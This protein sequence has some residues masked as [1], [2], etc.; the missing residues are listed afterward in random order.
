MKPSIVA[1]KLVGC[2]ITVNHLPTTFSIF[3]NKLNLALLRHEEFDYGYRYSKSYFGCPKLL[4]FIIEVCNSHG[5]IDYIPKDPWACQMSIDHSFGFFLPGI[6]KSISSKELKMKEGHTFQ[7]LNSSEVKPTFDDFDPNVDSLVKY[8][9]IF[10]NNLEIS[11]QFY[12]NEL[13]LSLLDET[14]SMVTLI[15]PLSVEIPTSPLRQAL[16]SNAHDNTNNKIIN[17]LL[18]GEKFDCILRLRRKNNKG[19]TSITE[20]QE[21]L[22]LCADNVL[23][24]NESTEFSNPQSWRISIINQFRILLSKWT[25]KIYKSAVSAQNEPPKDSP[26]LSLYFQFAFIIRNG[27]KGIIEYPHEK[28][29]LDRYT[30]NDDINIINKTMKDPDGNIISSMPTSMKELYQTKER[31]ISQK[32]TEIQQQKHDQRN[33]SSPVNSVSKSIDSSFE[34]VM[35]NDESVK[36]PVIEDIDWFSRHWLYRTIPFFISLFIIYYVLEIHYIR[37]FKLRKTI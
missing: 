29:L 2:S 17:S 24:A 19:P 36:L 21:T 8:F 13:G 15:S 10:V 12:M 5:K 11:K 23:T 22:V 14:N 33:E 7:L 37:L 16:I 26:P 30:L 9:D 35:M 6:K 31:L 20:S 34:A 27:P 32:L 28:T 18:N 3:R 25:N 1:R 4:N